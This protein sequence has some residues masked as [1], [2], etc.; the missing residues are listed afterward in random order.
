MCGVLAAF[1]AIITGV[2]QFDLELGVFL[3]YWYTV[4]FAGVRNGKNFGLHNNA[5]QQEQRDRKKMF[6]EVNEFNGMRLN[7]FPV[8]DKRYVLLNKK[9]AG[10]WADRLLFGFRSH[11]GYVPGFFF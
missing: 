5:G 10:I 11:L 7:F 9:A 8:K 4:G 1:V 3:F 2:I 6:H